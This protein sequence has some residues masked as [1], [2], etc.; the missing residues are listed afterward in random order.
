MERLSRRGCCE[1]PAWLVL[2]IAAIRRN[3]RLKAAEPG[4]ESA[5]SSIAISLQGRPCRP[6]RQQESEPTV[7]INPRSRNAH[8]VGTAQA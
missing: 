5:S 3:C 2:L 8:V 4:A 1:R 6:A 7:A